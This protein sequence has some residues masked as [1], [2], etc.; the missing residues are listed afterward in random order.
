MNIQGSNLRAAL[1]RHREER[2]AEGAGAGR[3]N[4]VCVFEG[5]QRSVTGGI[6]LGQSL[7]ALAAPRFSGYSSSLGSRRRDI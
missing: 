1:Q 5:K 3:R 2:A 4:R 6:P 7:A